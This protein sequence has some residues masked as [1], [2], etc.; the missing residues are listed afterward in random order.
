MDGEKNLLGMIGICRGARATV[1]GTAL[2]C[3]ELRRRG[4]GY[5]HI[6]VV[7]ASDSSDNTHKKIT[8][9]C[10]Y[11]NA[12]HVRL[13]V[14]STALGRAVGKTAV[15]VVAIVGEHFCRAVAGKLPG[16]DEQ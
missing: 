14:D 16:I 11:Y 5:P 9:K 1:I 2:V 10:L 6:L 13:S 12:R 8:D 15:S 3:E 4:K 7:E